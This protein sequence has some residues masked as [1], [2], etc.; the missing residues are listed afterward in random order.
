MKAVK[1][2]IKEHLANFYLIRRLSLYELKQAY[3]GNMLGVLWVFLNPFTQIG[4]Y[5]LVFG[6]GI[7]GG[8]PVHGVPYFVWLVCG[9]IPWFFISASIS[10]G[11]NSIYGRLNTVSKMNFPLSVIP[12]YV[13]ISQLYTHCILVVLLVIIS[14]ISQG[15][16]MI[17]IVGLLYGMFSSTI[18]LISLGFITSTLSTMLRDIHLLVQSITR[19]LFFLTPIFWEPKESM[20]EV[21]L[22]IVKLNP[23]YYI[24]EIYRGTV[25]YGQSSIIF[26]SYTLYFWGMVI[27]LLIIGSMLH[28]K[29][30]KQ[31]VDYL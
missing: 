8:A 26:S 17:N 9:L 6:L 15:W 4:V 27:I 20:P 5:W 7:R 12:T 2:I 30:R 19:M 22:L 3:A 29:F 31:F 24:L 14:L 10:Q 23:F 16:H 1:T 21:F 18:L 11:S 28:I 13:V 25:V